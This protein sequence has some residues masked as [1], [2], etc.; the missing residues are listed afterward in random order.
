MMTKSSSLTSHTSSTLALQAVFV[1]FIGLVPTVYATYV[2]N[3]ITLFSDF[4]RCFVE[5]LAVL[6]AWLVVRRTSRIDLAAYNYGFGKFEHIGSLA[7]ALAMFLSFLILAFLV[8]HRLS[9]PVVLHS[10]EFGFYV[11][12]I[13]IFANAAVAWHYFRCSRAAPSPL[14]SS[15]CR[16]FVA[17][18]VASIIVVVSILASSL[19]SGVLTSHSDQIGSALVALFLLHSAYSIVSSSMDDLVDRSIEEVY[20]LA[21]LR[22]LVRHEGLYQGFQCVRSRRSGV[23]IY[24]DILLEFASDAQMA[25]VSSAIVKIEEELNDALPGGRCTVVVRPEEGR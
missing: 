14:I 10:T 3:S 11:S 7:L 1:T 4:L 9:D 23:H 20:Q 24:V 5:F 16:L 19:P 21:I 22:I 12:L 13:A 2:S 25:E 8:Q 18:T 17:K 6:F 15:Q